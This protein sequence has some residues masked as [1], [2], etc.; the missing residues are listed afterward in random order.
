M[1]H[2]LLLIAWIS[3]ALAILSSLIIT[4]DLFAGHRQHMVIMNLVWPITALWAGPLALL[5]Y[6]RFGRLSTHR[7]MMKAKANHEPPAAKKKPFWAV[8]ALAA[9]H[10]GAGC[11][12]GDILAEW[13][14]FFFPPLL[15]A[16]GYGSLFAHKIFAAWILDFLLAFLLG[17][18]FQYFTIVPMRHLPP[19]QG[20]WHALVPVEPVGVRLQVGQRLAG[21]LV[22]CIRLEPE[23]GR[24]HHAPE[25][26]EDEHA[27]V[28]NVKVQLCPLT[29]WIDVRRAACRDEARIEGRKI[30]TEPFA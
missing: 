9:T 16:F 25:R 10:C 2:P 17:I 27:A 21:G 12:L 26:F 4:I 3:L 7:A 13:A 18:L 19:L 6:F 23:N 22:T 24:R 14:V 28:F 30:E 8:S 20:L 29:I 1:S 5:L 15:A 11:T